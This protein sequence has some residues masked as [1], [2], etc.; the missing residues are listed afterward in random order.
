MVMNN[1][2]NLNVRRL[3]VGKHGRGLFFS[4]PLGGWGVDY[5]LAGEFVRDSPPAVLGSWPEAADAFLRRR[6]VRRKAI[7]LRFNNSGR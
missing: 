3:T 2:A 5:N 7:S 1:A 6:R 4:P